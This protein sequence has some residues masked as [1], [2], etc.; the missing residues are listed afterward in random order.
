MTDELKVVSAQVDALDGMFKPPKGRFLGADAAVSVP[1][2][3]EKILWL[4][5]DTFVGKPGAADRV[6][7][8]FIRNSIAIYEPNKQDSVQYYWKEVA[9]K[10]D[11]FFDADEGFFYWPGT[12]VL[13]EGELLLFGHKTRDE[14]D[15]SFLPF[16]TVDATL[17][18][19]PNPKDSPENWI[20]NYQNLDMGE[21]ISFYSS[22]M[23]VEGEYFYFIGGERGKP[24]SEML[25]AR[26]FIEGIQEG[27]GKKAYEFWS[28]DGDKNRWSSSPEHPAKLS[29]PGVSETTIQYDPEWKLYF[30]TS[31]SI[32]NPAINLHYA[33]SLTG[34]WKGPL[35]LYDIP[36]DSLSEKYFSYAA[37]P[38][39]ELSTKQGEIIL[40][41][42]VN[43]KDFDGLLKEMHLYYPR[44]VRVQLERKD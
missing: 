42:A 36:E 35:K 39:P 29:I 26:A 41:Y 14:H 44:F 11:S 19:I 21:D 25:L 32:T 34:P 37:K 38:H 1:L 18:R 40:T 43:S 3:P 4:F 5:G 20:Q 27:L 7:S 9:G 16:R 15:G 33:S 17:M 30:V 10:P 23:V 28:E 13:F 24:F 22:G 31:Y 2:S 6:G 12:G 8:A